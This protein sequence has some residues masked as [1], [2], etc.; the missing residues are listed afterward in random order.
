MRKM[1]CC[2]A[3]L[4]VASLAACGTDE[5]V[6]KGP[7]IGAGDTS[8][9]AGQLDIA[10][11]DAT[12]DASTVDTTTSDTTARATDTTTVDPDTA[13]APDTTVVD[14]DVATQD[15]GPADS[16]PDDGGVTT[17][18]GT[19][20]GGAPDGGT[21]DGGT[22]DGGTPDGGSTPDTSGGCVDNSDCDGKIALQPCFVAVCK[23]SK[24]TVALS[25]AGSPCDDG[26]ACSKDETCSAGT[27]GGGKNACGCKDDAACDDK[28]PCTT[29]VCGADGKCAY[30]AQDGAK[31]DDGDGCTETG[32]CAADGTCS[33]GVA[34]DC[35]DNNPCTDDTC[36]PAT[37]CSSAS[38]TL[39]C[40]DDNACTDKDVCANGKCVAGTKKV[41]DDGAVCTDD[42]CD[43]K[44]GCTTKANTAK[45]D[46]G[47]GCSKDDVCKAG[48]CAGASQLD[49]DDKDPC[50]I[51]TCDKVAGCKSTPA[52]DGGA[53]DD[54]NACSE[55]DVCTG[56]KCAGAAVKTCDDGN[57]CT[58]DVCDSKTGCVAKNNTAKCADDKTCTSGACAA[59]KC[60]LGTTKGCDD[61]NAC[62]TDTCDAT[63]GCVYAAVKAGAACDDGDKCSD[64]D[65]CTAG[66]C[67]GKPVDCDDGNACTTDACG[68]TT[69][70]S[71]TANSANCDDGNKCTD[72]DKCKGGKCAGT[73]TADPKVAC[74]DKNACTDDT[75][76]ATTGCVHKPKAA[77]ATCDGKLVGDHC[78]RAFT[79]NANW[80]NSENAC[81]TWGGHLASISDATEDAAVRQL[82]QATCGNNAS[83]M[84]G[85]SD[86]TTEGTWLWNDGTPWKYT[87]WDSGQPSNSGGGGGQD[88]LMLRPNGAW[89]DLAANDVLGCRICER[90]MPKA[91]CDDGDKCTKDEFCTGD[92]CGGGVL[93]G[94]D[95][96]KP[97]TIDKC[98]AKT[99]ACS[100]AGKTGT[101]DDG[102]V[103]TTGE[104][105]KAGSCVGGAAV[106]CDD[107][108]PCT[109]DKCDPK[110]GKCAN[111]PNSD[112]CS[113]GSACTTSDACGAGKCAGVAKDCSDGDPCTNDACD[114][115]TG[116]CTHS[117][118]AGCSGCKTAADCDDANPCTD[119]AC[120]GSTGKCS[121]TFNKKTCDSGDP[122]TYGDLCDGAG[123]CIVGKNNA[124]DDDNSCTAD[125]CDKATGKCL[126]TNAADGGKCDDGKACTT[127]DVCKAGVCAPTADSCDLM[128]ETFDCGAA[129]S[130]WSLGTNGG[131]PELRWS[132][133]NAP[134][135][136]PA[137]KGCN[138]NYNDGTDYCRPLFGNNCYT[139]NQSA[140][141]P[142]INASA[143][144]GTPR[145]SFM[146]YYDLDGVDSTTTDLP[147]VR[148][149]A[150]NQTLYQFTLKKDAASM[151]VWRQI[152]VAVPNIKGRNNVRVRFYLEPASGANGNA[153][154]GWFIDDLRLTRSGN[155]VPEDCGD[156]I[157]NDGDGKIDCADADCKAEAACVENCTD[158]KDND[159]DDQVDCKDA[160][161]A[162]APSCL[163]LS[164]NCDD[165]QACTTDSCDDTTGK[166]VHIDN[167]LTCD[168]GDA[169]TSGDGC[170]GGKCVGAAKDCSDGDPCTTDSCDAK[171]GTCA[172][173]KIVGC[174]GCKTSADCGDGNVCTDDSCD[175]S[176]GKCANTN[177]TKACDGGDVC[178]YGD[179]C[180]GTGSCKT[181]TS[182]TCEDGNV[183]TIDSCD[184]KTGACSYAH[185]KDGTTCDDGKACTTGDACKAGSCVPAKADCPLLSYG[186]DCGSS[187]SGWFLGSN[188]GN[189]VLA[190]AVDNTPANE[191]PK[192]SGASGGCNLNYND[193]TDYC[194]PAFGN[195]CYTPNQSAY[196]PTFSGVGV[197]GTPK[198]TFWTYYDLDGPGSNNTDRPHVVIYSG[199]TA[200][201]DFA[202]G[203]ATSDMKN[204]HK[205]TFDVPNIKTRTNLRI[206]FVL[207]PASGQGGNTG[208]GWFIDDLQI[209]SPGDAGPALKEICGDG[210]DNDGNKLIDCADTACKAEASCQEVCDDG[211]D[212]DLDDKIDCADPDCVGHLSCTTPFMAANMDCG[213]KSWVASKA[214]NNVMWAIDATPSSVK[215]QTGACTLNFNNGYTFCGTP[216]CAG[217]SNATA[218]TATYDQTIDATGYKVLQ[219][220]YWSY[221]HGQDPA[222]TGIYLDVGMLQASTDDFAG[223]CNADNI[224]CQWSAVNCNTANTK[225]FLAPKEA[226]SWKKWVK[227]SADLKDFAGKKFKLRYRFSS[228]GTDA[229]NLPGWFV[230]D[231]ALIGTK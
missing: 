126:H 142:T 179:V 158:G 172:H 83:A 127:G 6:E 96:G 42:G 14:P 74:D 100:W 78:Y 45:C 205:L 174:G 145:L 197:T 69:G 122:C 36:D 40:D 157:D 202:L 217:T 90:V 75:C 129:L 17:D 153:G 215:P 136:G 168:D 56:G 132:V 220:S 46:D 34:K 204:W 177:N 213:D 3:L 43:P 183:C 5:G 167:K 55:K 192:A 193:G 188:G 173:A 28:N 35:D 206:R 185:T 161:C 108:N 149:Y 112:P 231:L 198:L 116:A 151:K 87:H 118:I 159:L 184:S 141:T 181:G 165:K 120:D 11:S 170:G 33:K 25:P 154:K 99:G 104:A 105:C 98:D 67:V 229:N 111:T 79:G 130:G 18:G 203:K 24:C 194:R 23:E 102:D 189:P 176:T 15:G 31:C 107:K 140:Y 84:L 37:G 110:T 54:G 1:R 13:V 29:D 226:A 20:D 73:T 230:D 52:K 201:H 227:T 8:V 4:V 9:D 180:D 50:T 51:D 72:G 77:A 219:A 81:K 57:P 10:A 68:A 155:Q 148:V 124:C 216:N 101:C 66:K 147:R 178:S 200:L 121:T 214:K 19:P 119:E 62:T 187:T 97:C 199:N 128:F 32:I 47:D 16:G 26:D 209:S 164:L 22:P 210:K 80:G 82:V 30:N 221:M 2:L 39:T 143:A 88:Y 114:A 160:D 225:T 150:G 223:C 137:G 211:K 58:D 125:S 212:N 61:N 166:C 186:F 59:G 175:V 224:S 182:K 12:E 71:W 70:C 146:T 76:E 92:K 65:V 86:A 171:T 49:C 109:T 190:W 64:A 228:Q 163:C 117:K 48:K 133:D 63:K 106:N 38:N 103:C 207:N 93:A 113:D 123:K 91:A 85:A 94:C 222:G 169:C 134:A 191:S 196:S 7:T 162:Q 44:T 53:C 27:C 60:V 139:P 135:I 41:C 89:N 95:D 138:L 152:D 208:K 218:G 156:G 21:P 195:N 131:N 144:T 115:K